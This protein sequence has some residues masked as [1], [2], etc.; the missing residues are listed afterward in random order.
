[1]QQILPKI[2]CFL[3]QSLLLLLLLIVVVCQIPWRHCFRKECNVSLI[4][5][6]VHWLGCTRIDPVWGPLS[7]HPWRTAEDAAEIMVRQ[8][9]SLL[10]FWSFHH[11]RCFLQAQAYALPTRWY[12]PAFVSARLWSGS[13]MHDIIK[14]KT[15]MLF[16]SFFFLYKEKSFAALF[17]II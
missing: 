8:W 3:S 15:L 16:K 4:F 2:R 13:L 17:L 12:Q 6:A 11:P 7:G 1:M 10:W 5:S 14:W 9:P